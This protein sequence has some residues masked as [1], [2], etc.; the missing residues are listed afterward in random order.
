MRTVYRWRFLVYLVAFFLSSIV[1]EKTGGAILSRIPD[2]V[3]TAA[4]F[5]CALLILLGVWIRMLS[6]AVLPTGRAWAMDM[7]PDNITA[8]GP[9]RYMIH[10]MYAGNTLIFLSLL[11]FY[12]V[13]GGGAFILTTSLV[14]VALVRYEDRALQKR[15]LC[16]GIISY[17]FSREA[18]T[19][20]VLNPVRSTIPE[21]PNLFVVFYVLFL[22]RADSIVSMLD[23]MIACLFLTLSAVY[24]ERKYGNL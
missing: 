18:I 13:A 16:H 9:Y 5:L 11:P 1:S 8:T 2:P 10:P 17:L 22:P 15:P 7:Q 20:I 6:H 3:Q 24:L 21:I 4:L 12:S 14:T 23:A 19:S